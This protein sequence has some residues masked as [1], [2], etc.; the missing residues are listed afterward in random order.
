[1]NTFQIEK[2]IQFL[3]KLQANDKYLND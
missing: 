3:H 2:S 1:L